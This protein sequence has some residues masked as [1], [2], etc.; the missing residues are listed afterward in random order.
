MAERIKGE[1][2]I[3]RWCTDHDDWLTVAE[4]TAL[5]FRIYPHYPELQPHYTVPP[6]SEW[7]K[8]DQEKGCASLLDGAD[9]VGSAPM[10][11]RSY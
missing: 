1:A 10:M 8:C 6:R 7:K 3:Q 11:D 4:S 2:V 9:R 5:L